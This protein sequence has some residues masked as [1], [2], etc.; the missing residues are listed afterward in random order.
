MRSKAGTLIFI[1]ED[2]DIARAFIKHEIEKEFAAYPIRVL[3]FRTG[4][5]CR[6]VNELPDIAVVDYFLNSRYK[7]A[8][9]GMAVAEM[10]KNKNPKTEI[11]LF[12][13]EENGE[14]ARR[15]VAIGIKDYIVKNE[16]M[17]LKLRT[18]LLECIMLKNLKTDLKRQKAMVLGAVCF[19]ILVLG[20]VLSVEL[21]VPAR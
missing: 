12:T 1:I 15:A 4:E 11:I 19:A 18:S 20:T 14:I 21:L 7:E 17:L 6:L 8:M 9:N 13:A 2:D 5:Q 3:G 16:L 10:L